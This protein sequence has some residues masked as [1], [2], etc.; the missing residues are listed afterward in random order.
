MNQPGNNFQKQSD[1]GNNDQTKI[2]EHKSFF[3]KPIA[4]SNIGFVFLALQ[5]LVTIVSYTFRNCDMCY[6]IVYPPLFLFGLLA[7]V[8]FLIG[9]KK[10]TTISI[11]GIMWVIISPMMIW[12]ILRLFN[13]NY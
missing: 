11:L 1:Y 5:L 3:N 7:I 12:S 13:I 4:G 10:N 8:F 6:L 2:S 9:I